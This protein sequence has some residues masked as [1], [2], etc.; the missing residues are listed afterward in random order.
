MNLVGL[1]NDV[2]LKYHKTNLGVEYKQDQFDPVSVADREAEDVLRAGV[3]RLLPGAKILGEEN[4]LP[5]EDW[6]GMVVVID[7][8]DDSKNYLR[9]GDLW[10]SMVAELQDG[11]PIRAVVS[12]PLRNEWYV[13]EKGKGSFVIRGGVVTPLRVR[14]TTAVAGSVLVG[15]NALAG[16]I[17]PIDEVIAQMPFGSIVPEGSIGG[18]VG[19]IA[20]GKADAFIHTNLKSGKWDTAPNELIL[21]EAG[22]V[23][24]DIDGK[25]LDYTKPT[26]GWDRFFMAAA[27]PELLTEMTTKLREINEQTHSF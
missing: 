25:L 7:P 16:D 8:L 23:M 10:A 1:A 11:E 13:A 2:L 6:R 4:P 17:R 27:T 22:G 9:G 14:P 5:P 15:R 21:R 20:E 3:E 18:K 24:S 26:N 12:R 19:L